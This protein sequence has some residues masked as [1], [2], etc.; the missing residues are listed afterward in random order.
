MI[1]RTTEIVR[2]IFVARYHWLLESR[3]QDAPCRFRDGCLL[4]SLGEGAVMKILRRTLV[5]MGAIVVGCLIGIRGYLF[6]LD[7]KIQW[8]DDRFHQVTLGQTEPELVTLLGKPMENVNVSEDP[9][10]QKWGIHRFYVYQVDRKLH[11][12]TRPP[13]KWTI[14]LNRHGK[15]VS[16]RRDD[17]GC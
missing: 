14:G 5:V 9:V 17:N 16:M 11:I 12:L 13:V 15:V 8:Y 7:A 1:G 2:P 4:N 3:R 6:T 10:C